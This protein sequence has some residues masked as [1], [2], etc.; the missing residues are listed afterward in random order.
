[1]APA[2]RR[3]LWG[4]GAVFGLLALAV[5]AVAIAL[6]TEWGRERV[7][8]A[9]RD[10]VAER[11]NGRVELGGAALGITGGAELHGVA[12]YDAR[13]E[14]AIGA[15]RVAVECAVWQLVLRGRVRCSS[16]RVVAPVVYEARLPEL[17]LPS[18]DP[19]PEPLDVV[20]DGVVVE[21]GRFVRPDGSEARDLGARGQVVL[22]AST[23]IAVDELAAHWAPL[24]LDVTAAGAFEIGEDGGLAAL[25]ASAATARSR[26]A[27]V[28][29]EPGVFELDGVVAEADVP[30]APLLRDVPFELTVTVGDGVAARGEVG[31]IALDVARSDAGVVS[32]TLTA[33]AVDPSTWVEGAPVGELTATI[34]AD[35]VAAGTPGVDLRSA[36]GTVTVAVA[37]AIE[38]ESI[39]ELTL[40]VT[41]GDGAAELRGELATGRGT[42]TVAAD[43]RLGDDD[44]IV[45][46]LAKV[47]GDVAPLL[48]FVPDLRARSAVADV[49]A[50][51]TLEA[52]DV[53]GRV[54]LRGVRYEDRTAEYVE[55]VA[56][57]GG[58]SVFAP[59]ERPSGE[60]EVTARDL[61]L[62]DTA[63]GSVTA[64]GRF[65]RGGEALVLDV[66]V[67][68]AADR[69]DELRTRAR[70]E[71]A[72]DRT[73]VSLGRT[74]VRA[75]GLTWEGS[76]ARVVAH[77]SGRIDVAGARLASSAG[78]VT[79][80]GSL[81][82]A[83]PRA[84]RGNLVVTVDDLDLEATAGLHGLALDGVVDA[85]ADLS[86]RGAEV[87]IA[88]S[89]STERVRWH[90]VA[91]PVGGRVAVTLDGGML[92]VTGDLVHVG[93]P[94]KLALQL[95]ATAPAD[96]TDAAAWQ[97]RGLDAVDFLVI[98]ARGLDAATADLYAGEPLGARGTA[99]VRLEL[100]RDGRR[101]LGIE[102]EVKGAAYGE[103]DRVDGTVRATWG[104]DALSGTVALVHAG[105][106]V[107][108]AEVELGVGLERVARAGGAAFAGAAIKL[109]APLDGFELRRLHRAGLLVEPIDGTLSAD[110]RVRGTLEAPELELRDGRGVG[111]RVAGVELRTLELSGSLRGDTVAARVVGVQR[112]GGRLSV[113]GTYD[114]GTRRVV[115]DLAAARFDLA[116]L[117][118]FATDPASP[119]AEIAGRLDTDPNVHLEG[120][121]D[122]PLGTGV[123]Q[124]TDGALLLEG[125]ARRVYDIRATVKLDGERIAVE[126]LRAHTGDGRIG[127]SG[128]LTVSGTKLS[129]LSLQVNANDFPYVAGEYLIVVDLDGIVTAKPEGGVWKT[130]ATIT[131]GTVT[132][133]ETGAALQDIDPLEDVV[134]VDERALR[135]Q[136]RQERAASS[137]DPI[138]AV[139]NLKLPTNGVRIKQSEV[140]A[141][142]VGDA[143]L[144]LVD[145]A[146]TRMTGRFRVKEGTVSLMERDYDIT[147]AEATL[148]GPI[149]PDPEVTIELRHTF[150]A[151]TVIVRVDGKVSDPKVELTSDGDYDETEVLAIMLGEDPNDPELANRTAEERVSG[152]AQSLVAREL[153]DIFGLPLDV[154]RR[155][156]DGWE[157][158]TWVK[159]LGRR[160]L[161]GYRYRESE[162]QRENRNEGTFEL[163]LGRGVNLEGRAGDR[164]VIGAD[165]VWV[166]RF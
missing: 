95:R 123:I 106:P 135:R 163:P 35:D 137:G 38:G 156:D 88:A 87:T 64:D 65:E 62:G 33:A 51:G 119:L 40:A 124:L 60:L 56:G 41:A 11:V 77:A 21:G 127:A 82:P 138:R 76:G 54:S 150:P 90:D 145:F 34:T 136:R 15:D 68:S 132:L 154:I 107:T 25:D 164:S 45:I 128:Q 116:I 108:T 161:L 74:T 155:H 93:H 67:T 133:S 19:D 92:V 102:V 101:V 140:D 126:R 142:V 7:R 71:R 78:A 144:E 141:R 125:G 96:P 121:I 61:R 129:S 115:A 50:S 37:G 46:E 24:A 104:A 84:G 49:S 148:D 6:H 149:P 23:A 75:G 134:F 27:V 30:F 117:R 94:G 73:T 32:G 18:D 20:L 59:P 16:L 53:D 4:A 146:L 48:A 69:V 70:I 9:V 130:D 153:R 3:V 8:R 112:K 63:I 52:L 118:A 99:D 110:L 89:V 147:I 81:P 47:S 91:P 85:Q 28:M 83:G 111:V 14:L 80:E 158:G 39:E 31:P 57:V 109:D 139:V 79:A 98:D 120:A 66:R 5:I 1:M 152:F 166:L 13:G 58:I 22:T 86:R 36:R 43:A 103:I 17:F 122:A 162:D 160:L 42:G 2:V 143:R 12:I 72:P 55:V 26:V 157:L 151:A 114:L 29:P 97:R 10:A 165:L 100:P 113:T 159:V 44:A 131:R 105:A